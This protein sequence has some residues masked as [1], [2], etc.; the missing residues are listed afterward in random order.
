MHQLTSRI[1]AFQ[2]NGTSL[3]KNIPK[4]INYYK[5]RRVHIFMPLY[6][7]SLIT[8]KCRL[9]LCCQYRVIDFKKR[10]ERMSSVEVSDG[11]TS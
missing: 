3:S 11:L 10:K 7:L 4:E 9:H 2:D 1:R 6:H 5:I 8:E